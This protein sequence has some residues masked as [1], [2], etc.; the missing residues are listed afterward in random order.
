MVVSW[1]SH[2][3]LLLMLN[4]F[5]MLLVS[6]FQMLRATNGGTTVG[7]W[8]DGPFSWCSAWFPWWSWW[9]GSR[10]YVLGN[11]WWSF[12]FN[13]W[14]P[15][16]FFGFV[17]AFTD[18]SDFSSPVC[19]RYKQCRWWYRN[20]SGWYYQYREIVRAAETVCDYGQK[21]VQWSA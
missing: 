16:H 15:G 21:K 12:V 6:L 2:W 5:S 18:S 8:R 11:W 7:L 20:V 14:F 3:Q 1:R 10:K 4:V 9:Q 19:R 13:R 17:P